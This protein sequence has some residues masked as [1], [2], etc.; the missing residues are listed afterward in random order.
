MET[1]FKKGDCVKLKNGNSPKMNV[2]AISVNPL[3]NA[4]EIKCTWSVDQK[5]QVQEFDAEILKPCDTVSDG[6]NKAMLQELIPSR[7]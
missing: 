1:N 6:L 5:M 3:S 2:T 7:R 4:T